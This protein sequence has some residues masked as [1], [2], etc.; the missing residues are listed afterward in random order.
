MIR[1]KLC[2]V[3]VLC[4]QLAIPADPALTIYNQGFSVI[5]EKIPIEWHAGISEVRFAGATA[6][7]EPESVILRDLA[8][9]QQFQ[10]LEQNY[11][12]DPISQALLLS[13]FEGQ[14][15]DFETGN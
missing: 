12:N 5:R 13:L 14:T 11:R 9:S 1:P 10:I 15:I 4:A 6:H 7:V 2:L 8:A 3:F